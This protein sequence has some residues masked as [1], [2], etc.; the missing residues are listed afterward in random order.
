MALNKL[1]LDLHD[2]KSSSSTVHQ[3]S[4]SSQLFHVPIQYY[5]CLALAADFCILYYY[6]LLQIFSPNTIILHYINLGKHPM[7]SLRLSLVVGWWVT[8]QTHITLP[9]LIKWLKDINGL[10]LILVLR[11]FYLTFNNLFYYI[12][13]VSLTHAFNAYLTTKFHFEK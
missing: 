12:Y 7:V 6:W 2:K 3:M 5:Y 1:Y 13:I 8:R 10:R 9:W 11:T 4:I